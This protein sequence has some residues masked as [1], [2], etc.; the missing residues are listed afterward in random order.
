MVRQS[1]QIETMACGP[2]V[3]VI[4]NRK[5]CEAIPVS[6][7]AMI[8]TTGFNRVKIYNWTHNAEYM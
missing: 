3:F 6:I 8:F 1:G 5:P 4:A 7:E 2:I